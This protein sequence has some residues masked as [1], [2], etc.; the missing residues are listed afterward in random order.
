MDQVNTLLE[1]RSVAKKSFK[2]VIFVFPA[3]L[4]N[5]QDSPDLKAKGVALN[6][7]SDRMELERLQTYE[8]LTSLSMERVGQQQLQIIMK[9]FGVNETEK[10][11]KQRI[12]N[13]LW[14]SYDSAFSSAKALLM[15]FSELVESTNISYVKPSRKG[16]KIFGIK[17]NNPI[18]FLIVIFYHS[19][20]IFMIPK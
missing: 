18:N 17:R 6:N 20:V 5:H 14:Q 7:A 3:E 2:G 19:N 16:R 8:K 1:S 13:Y 11:K 9:M 10:L 12:T 4:A 15:I